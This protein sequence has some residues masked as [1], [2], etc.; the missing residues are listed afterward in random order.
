MTENIFDLTDVS[1]IPDE[2]ST[3]LIAICQTLYSF[4]YNA[5]VKE[6]YKDFKYEE[7]KQDD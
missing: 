4:V 2:I 6:L 1:D 3:E 7:L 5:K